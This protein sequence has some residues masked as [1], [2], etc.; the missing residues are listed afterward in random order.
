[1]PA[2]FLALAPDARRARPGFLRRVLR[3][4]VPAGLVAAAAT[5]TAYALATGPADGGVPVA[6]TAATV[7]LFGAGTTVLVLLARPWSAGRAVL[8]ATMVVTF[9]TLL[10]VPAARAFFAL[11]PLPRGVS[12]ATGLVIS[13][14]ALLLVVVW[15]LAGRAEAPDHAD[16]GGRMKGCV[17][18]G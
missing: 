12:L 16:E 10:A 15:R 5:F 13:V 11:T 1:V 7:A 2:F 4:A 8:V 3:F 14:A 9:V 18:P 17:R 6:R